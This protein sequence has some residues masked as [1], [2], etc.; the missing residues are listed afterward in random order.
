L[1][2]ESEVGEK[3]TAGAVPVP[4]RATVCGLPVALSV[5]ESVAL[6]APEACGEKVTLTV[7]PTP[8]AKLVPQLFVW[9]KSVLLV[10]VTAID[11][12]VSVAVPLLVR[13]T[14]WAVLLVPTA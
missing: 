14:S 2:K 10:P 6:R 4:V 11:V 8:A 3:V 5:T 13:V 1:P 7:Q 9:E 12:M